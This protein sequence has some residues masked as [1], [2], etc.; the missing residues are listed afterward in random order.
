MAVGGHASR[1]WVKVGL[2]YPLEF[3]VLKRD[4]V[5]GPHCECNLEVFSLVLSVNESGGRFNFIKAFAF[6][7]SIKFGPPLNLPTVITG[8]DTRRGGGGNSY[9]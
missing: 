1:A 7:A 4:P 8:S 2:A 9:R 6:S 5:W 3:G